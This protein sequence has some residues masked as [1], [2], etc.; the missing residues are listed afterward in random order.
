MRQSETEWELIADSHQSPL[1]AIGNQSDSE[2]EWELIADGTTIHP[3][4]EREWK[5]ITDDTTIHPQSEGEWKLIAE[6]VTPFH[7]TS[8]HRK[9]PSTLTRPRG[10]PDFDLPMSQVVPDMGLFV[11]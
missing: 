8:L 6:G 3:Q 1:L 11:G 10:T 2:R 9:S 7:I 5:L 4:S